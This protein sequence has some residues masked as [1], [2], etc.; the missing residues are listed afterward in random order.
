MPPRKRRR[1]PPPRTTPGKL[2]PSN[3]SRHR[4]VSTEA[5]GRPS[6]V[7]GMDAAFEFT[8]RLV[9]KRLGVTDALAE[10]AVLR[11]EELLHRFG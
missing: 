7:D 3:I 5:E 4:D 6:A 10:V 2:R 1:L 9:S 11:Y 8:V